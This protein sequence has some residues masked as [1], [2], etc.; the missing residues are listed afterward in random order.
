MGTTRQGA[1]YAR[2]LDGGR[3][4]EKVLYR[5]EYT[6][7]NEVLI[8]PRDPNILYATLW[9][10]QQSFI[11]GQGFGGAGMGIFKSTDGGTT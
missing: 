4:F 5:D 6:S 9:Q 10:Q 11:E 1:F 7:A 8:D 2:S 3:S